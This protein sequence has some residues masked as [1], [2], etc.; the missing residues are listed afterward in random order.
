MFIFISIISSIV[1]GV[2][3]SMKRPPALGKWLLIAFIFTIL[4]LN[5]LSIY[6]S[7]LFDKFEIGHSIFSYTISFNINIFIFSLLSIVFI[8]IV[9]ISKLPAEYDDIGLYLA[10]LGL[11]L[12]ALASE[13]CIYTLIFIFSLQVVIYHLAYKDRRQRDIANLDRAFSWNILAM[14]LTII[15]L[16][17]NRYGF[18]WAFYP[19]GMPSSTVGS[20][21]MMIGLVGLASQPP[22]HLWLSE[23]TSGRPTNSALIASTFAVI[24][25]FYLIMKVGAF[26]MPGDH[27][28]IVGSII[29][30]LGFLGLSAQALIESRIDRHAGIL[31]SALMGLSVFTILRMGYQTHFAI[32]IIILLSASRLIS[33][34]TTSALER[35]GY[36]RDMRKFTSLLGEGKLLSVS[37]IIQALLIFP[38]FAIALYPSLLIS[39]ALSIRV[40]I[41][42]F[43]VIIIGL[44]LYSV[45]AVKLL[46]S[47]IGGKKVQKKGKK[48]IKREISIALIMAN[49]LGIILALWILFLPLLRIVLRV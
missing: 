28:I 23:T 33:F 10:G 37:I 29:G 20:I 2:I 5:I 24:P 6:K 9:S 7:V 39:T 15:G 13:K 38:I 47:T 30:I 22:F 12:G 16:S 49:S 19:I 43:I 3:F 31:T 17:L 14:L 27:A 18:N 35:I 36:N 41:V 34:L 45:N 42:I 11:T 25:P 8:L 26:V 21:L 48:V 1:I 32:V 40:N 4:I 44:I 46:E